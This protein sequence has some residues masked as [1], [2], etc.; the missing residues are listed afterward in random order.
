MNEATMERLTAIKFGPGKKLLG[1]SHYPSGVDTTHFII[2][3]NNIIAIASAAEYLTG[4]F[5]PDDNA[6]D[7][8]QIARNVFF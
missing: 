6:S 1:E 5:D 4:Y 2:Q 7:M 3:I 8:E